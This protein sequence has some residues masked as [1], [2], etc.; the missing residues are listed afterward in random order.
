MDRTEIDGL[1]R[2][3][4]MGDNAAFEKLYAQTRRGVY[5]FLYTYFHN[6][7]DTED[8]LQ[9]VYLKIKMNIVGYR[10]GTNARAWILQIA[11]NH[12][13]NELR[14]RKV[15]TI[16][17]EMVAANAVDV[18]QDIENSSGITEVMQKVLSEDEQR[19][20]TLHVLWDYKHREIAKM[21]DSPLGTVL[22]KYKRAI[23]KMRKAL[24]EVEA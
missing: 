12:A 16:S 18:L 6:A 14:R 4:A 3:I 22:S 17:D 15:E 5:A 13:L 11:K 8:A 1:L 21:L 2:L 7:A 19:I 10:A 23:E 20:V 9:S 24:K